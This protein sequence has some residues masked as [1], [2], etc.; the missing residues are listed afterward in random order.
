M[1]AGVVFGSGDCLKGRSGVPKV[2]Q[3]DPR[4]LFCRRPRR[5]TAQ[6]RTHPSLEA[7]IKLENGAGRG[8]GIFKDGLGRDTFDALRCD[9]S[10][11]EIADSTWS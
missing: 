2:R 8:E 7:H 6:Q 11:R 1:H 4:A 5:N 9:W 10:N 3:I